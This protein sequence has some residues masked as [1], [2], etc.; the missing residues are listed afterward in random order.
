[1][2]CSIQIRPANSQQPFKSF[3]P[4]SQTRK[5]ARTCV[6]AHQVSNFVV[7]DAVDKSCSL[8]TLSLFFRSAGTAPHHHESTCCTLPFSVHNVPNLR[9]RR[10]SCRSRHRPTPSRRLCRA[11]NSH[12]R[13]SHH[14]S[15]ASQGPNCQQEPSLAALCAGSQQFVRSHSACGK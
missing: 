13:P 11:S 9:H 2:R 10:C 12:R 6:V 8:T 3:R 4:L 15:Q 5:C 1:M 14:P 7:V